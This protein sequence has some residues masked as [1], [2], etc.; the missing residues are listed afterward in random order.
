MKKD[1]IKE[2]LQQFVGFKVGKWGNIEELISSM[3]LTKEE[4]EHIK[5]NEESGNLDE[6]DIEKVN[7]YFEEED[8]K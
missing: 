1:L 7:K 3:A 6:D 2:A 8:E 5:E 4:W